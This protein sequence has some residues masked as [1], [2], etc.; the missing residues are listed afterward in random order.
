MGEALIAGLLEAGHDP[1]Q[2]CVAEFDAER[3]RV[4]EA[5]YPT[6]RVVPS[7]SW[8]LPDADVA[9]VAVKPADVPGVLTSALDALGEHTLVLSIAAGVTIAELERLGAGRPG[10]AG[11]AHTAGGARPGAAAHSRGAPP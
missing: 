10:G 5:L 4:L 11:M 6:V 1:D 8:A 9:V 2:L 7:A 3:R